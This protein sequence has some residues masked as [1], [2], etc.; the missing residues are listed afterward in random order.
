MKF[1]RIAKAQFIK[2][3]LSAWDDGNLRKVLPEYDEFYRG[4]YGGTVEECIKK[5][6]SDIYDKLKLP[7]RATVG[8]AGYDFSF[9]T[10]IKAKQGLQF[11]LPTGI[12]WKAGDVNERLVL[13]IYPRSSFGI[14][15]RFREPNL[16]SIIDSDY[17]GCAKNG[18]HIHMHLANEGDN[19]ELLVQPFIAYAQGVITNYYI[20]E[21]DDT[22]ATRVGGVG[23]TGV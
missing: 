7:K 4:V 16:V 5:F 23:S 15:Y 21:D 17:Y 9:P 22:T 6:A 11:T 14:R 18:G 20:T 19:G 10:R 12:A 8:S 3:F 2:D 13:S 1:E